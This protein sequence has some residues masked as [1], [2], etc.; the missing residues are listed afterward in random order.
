VKNEPLTANGAKL[1]PRRWLQGLSPQALK[2]L[3]TAWDERLRAKVIARMYGLTESQVFY[4]A[5]TLGWPSRRGAYREEK[6]IVKIRLNLE[7]YQRV[8]RAARVRET[9]MQGLVQHLIQE[10][11]DNGISASRPSVIERIRIPE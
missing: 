3:R 4:A 11:L 5:K 9:T 6:L 8:G 10:Y 2:T 7:T 1:S